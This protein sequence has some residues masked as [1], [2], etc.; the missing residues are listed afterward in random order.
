MYCGTDASPEQLIS[1]ALHEMRAAG[2]NWNDK[3][4]WGAVDLRKFYFIIMKM[5]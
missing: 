2:Y 4:L 5:I 1:A 3:R